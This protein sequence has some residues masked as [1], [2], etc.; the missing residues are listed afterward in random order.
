MLILRNFF[1]TISL[2]LLQGVLIVL[3][4]EEIVC[5]DSVDCFDG[6]TM[7]NKTYF[8][9]SPEKVSTSFRVFVKPDP[10]RYKQS[11][12]YRNVSTLSM[13]KKS[14]PIVLI[15]HG[16][17]IDSDSLM[18]VQLRNA[19]FNRYDTIVAVD[20]RRGASVDSYPQSVV[21]TALVGRETG[22]LIKLLSNYRDI[23]P[24]QIY[25]IGFSLGAHVAGAAG[26]WLADKLGAKAG[27]ITG[28]NNN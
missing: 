2:I 14:S 12:H 3:T 25:I 13:I 21:N 1:I 7:F 10:W 11:I 4:D 26:R 20:W 24:D 18:Y 6:L 27:R 15:V 19:L 17:V 22:Q 23:S 9:E 16:W 8:P 28:K 5:Y